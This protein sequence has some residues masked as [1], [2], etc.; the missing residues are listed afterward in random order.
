MR[1][2]KPP[3]RLSPQGSTQRAHVLP[4]LQA[5][6]VSLFVCLCVSVTVREGCLQAGMG[7]GKGGD[8]GHVIHRLEG[9]RG[10]GGC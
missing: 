1:G 3:P 2:I 5:L 8:T 6:S 7:W 4:L 9:P 10:A